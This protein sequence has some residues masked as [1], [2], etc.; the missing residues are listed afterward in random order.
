MW[1]LKILEIFNNF[2]LKIFLLSIDC[3]FKAHIDLKFVLFVFNFF[4]CFIFLKSTYCWLLFKLQSLSKVVYLFTYFCYYK[5]K[6]LV[7]E[8]LFPSIKVINF[9]F[10]LKNWILVDEKL[11][12]WLHWFC[13][14][15]Y[16]WWNHWKNC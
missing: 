1:F 12:V 14:I 5:N 8:L 7:L 4:V 2:V 9:Y 3:F 6:Y 16:L 15:I 10:L 11:N 13:K